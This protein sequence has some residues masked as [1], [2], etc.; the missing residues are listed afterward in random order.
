VFLAEF[1][2]YGTAYDEGDVYVILKDLINPLFKD[3]S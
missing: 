3:S 1:T 2:L